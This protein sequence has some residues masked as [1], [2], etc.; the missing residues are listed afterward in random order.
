[1][2]GFQHAITE[3]RHIIKNYHFRSYYS[4]LS[5]VDSILSFCLILENKT[6]VDPSDNVVQLIKAHS[7]HTLSAVSEKIEI[8]ENLGDDFM[9]RVFQK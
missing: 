2:A 3:I 8:F 6:D 7:L 1:L 4:T 5:A 9:D